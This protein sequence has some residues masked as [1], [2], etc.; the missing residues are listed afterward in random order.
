MIKEAISIQ[1]KFSKKNLK[2][3]GPEGVHWPQQSTDPRVPYSSI[4]MTTQYDTVKKAISFHFDYTYSI[5]SI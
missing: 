5:H 1:N 4:V 2:F 3:G